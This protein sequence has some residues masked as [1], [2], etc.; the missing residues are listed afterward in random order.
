[1]Y[2]YSKDTA[3]TKY[4]KMCKME[5]V[6]WIQPLRHLPARTLRHLNEEEV[7]ANV[8]A[9][10]KPQG[11]SCDADVASL[12]A[13]EQNQKHKR[14]LSFFALRKGKVPSKQADSYNL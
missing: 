13:S 12:K 14:I 10:D 7:K 8:R 4:H 6:L 11:S 1:M 2:V 5:L 9:E 3:P